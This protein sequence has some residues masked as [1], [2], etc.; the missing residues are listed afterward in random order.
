[1]IKCG[2]DK[3]LDL[4]HGHLHALSPAQLT[5]THPFFPLFKKIINSDPKRNDKLTDTRKGQDCFAK[6]SL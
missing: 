1:M 4:Q 2:S 3:Q 5:A 6:Q